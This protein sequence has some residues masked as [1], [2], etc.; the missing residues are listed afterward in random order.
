[1]LVIAA[2]CVVEIGRT[3]DV[4]RSDIINHVTAAPIV[5]ETITVRR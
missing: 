5:A 2:G 3:F 1:V 4:D